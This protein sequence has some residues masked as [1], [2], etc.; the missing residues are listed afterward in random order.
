MVTGEEAEED[1]VH[2][3][4]VVEQLSEHLVTS[5]IRRAV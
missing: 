3:A 2:L 1:I 5:A 4:I